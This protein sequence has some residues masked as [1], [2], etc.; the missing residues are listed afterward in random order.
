M[1]KAAFS[2]W[3]DRIAPVFDVAGQIHVVEIKA[4]KIVRESR[5]LLEELPPLQR[6]PRLVE[7]GIDTLICGAISRHLHELIA[8]NG[9]RVISFVTGDLSELIGIWLRGEFDG[10]A[11]AMPG[12]RARIRHQGGSM[13][14]LF[15]EDMIM[16]RGSGTGQG[17]GRGRGA[18]GG[19]RGR[20][21]GS[22]RA[23]PGGNCIC[24]R[25]G[26]KSP[27]GRGVPCFERKCPKCGTAMVRE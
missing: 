25:C 18:G 17:G 26:E 12:C 8:A 14:N 16:N 27:H 1:S 22:L 13:R 7:L 24:P 21:G 23:G 3:G 4:G 20:M 5:E 9:I 6:V 2:A 19:H 10:S 11:F 15:E